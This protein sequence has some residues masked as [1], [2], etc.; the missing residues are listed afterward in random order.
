VLRRAKKWKDF[1]VVNYV[2][3]FKTSVTV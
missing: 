2:I 3:S 1:D